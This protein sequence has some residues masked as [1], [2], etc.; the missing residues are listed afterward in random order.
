[1]KSDSKTDN[2]R[3]AR[4]G[5]EHHAQKAE[6]VESLLKLGFDSVLY[7]YLCSDAVLIG[8]AH[9]SPF[10]LALEIEL[11]ARNI[12]RNQDRNFQ[13]GADAT[14]VVCPDFHTMA[15]VA[16]KL[17]RTEKDS[18]RGRVGLVNLAGLRILQQQ[19]GDNSSST[20]K[21]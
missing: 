18:R 12:P 10:L 8:L 9:K 3:R 6:A 20:R 19:C 17:A 14:L 13:Q 5:D 21:E 4:Q 7:E 15:A 2:F 16:R 1:M 11:S